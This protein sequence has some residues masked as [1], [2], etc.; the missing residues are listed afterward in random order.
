MMMTPALKPNDLSESLREQSRVL[1]GRAILE[2]RTSIVVN[3]ERLLK[4]LV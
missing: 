2:L 4:E 3:G 1:S